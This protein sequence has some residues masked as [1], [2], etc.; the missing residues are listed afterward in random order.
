M[1]DE[2]LDQLAELLI[3]KLIEK[4]SEKKPVAQSSNPPS[5]DLPD[6]D[7]DEFGWQYAASPASTQAPAEPPSPPV[8]PVEGDRY[9]KPLPDH[10]WKAAPFAMGQNQIARD[11]QKN[12]IG[13]ITSAGLDPTRP[14]PPGFGN[15][16]SGID[17]GG[18]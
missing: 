3:P 10:A 6:W 7:W 17:V 9:A 1:N 2:A 4:L 11:Y 8:I 13:A 12:W 15:T 5:D 18:E 14:L 16:H